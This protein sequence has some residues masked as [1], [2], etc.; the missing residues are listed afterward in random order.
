[1]RPY[2]PGRARA[3]RACAVDDRGALHRR[4][5]AR[6]VG[7]R[8]RPLAHPGRGKSTRSQRRGAG[9]GGRDRRCACPGGEVVHRA[10]GAPRPGRS[11]WSRSRTGRRCRSRSRSWCASG[12][13]RWWRSTTPCCASTARRCSSCRA[14]R[15]HG[16]RGR[17]RP[18]RDRHDRRRAPGR[19]SARAPIEIALLFPVPHRTACERP[20]ATSAG[21]DPRPSTCAV[22][23]RGVGRAWMGTPTRS[24]HAGR[25][26]AARR[27]PR[28]RGA[29]RSPARRAGRIPGVV[30]ALE[31]WGFDDEAALGLGRARVGAAPGA[32]KVRDADPWSALR[33]SIRPRSGRV[34]VGACASCSRER[35]ARSIC[36]PASR[37]IGSASP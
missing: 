27:R 13:A 7:R 36:C 5:R 12:A 20:S 4:P 32:A 3:R 25:A 9:A 14:R 18:S 10:Y 19:S 16:R 15:A 24:G 22:A 30:A 29:R 34:P 26:T 23:R 1:M 33:A 28:R 11:S 6:L 2:E 37:P 8:R 31:D 21:P 17:R 35:P